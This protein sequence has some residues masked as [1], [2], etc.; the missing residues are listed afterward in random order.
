M[1]ASLCSRYVAQ[2]E[3]ASSINKLQSVNK[4]RET[5]L[6]YIVLFTQTTSVLRRGNNRVIART[7]F[8]F[9][10]EQQESRQRHSEQVP[11][12]GNRIRTTTNFMKSTGNNA[13]KM[14]ITF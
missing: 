12:E 6:K 5:K 10:I 2:C 7:H 9:Y 11:I 14:L 13:I 8:Y 4:S 3:P 1:Y